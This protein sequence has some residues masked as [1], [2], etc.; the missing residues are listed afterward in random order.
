MTLIANQTAFALRDANQAIVIDV[1]EPAEYVEAHLDGAINLP[2]T[3]FNVNDYQ[4]FGDRAICLICQTGNRAAHIAADLKQHGIKNVYLLEQQMAFLQEKELGV[5][6]GG[7]TID[8][9]FR[10][11]L[12]LLLAIFLVGYFWGVTWFIIIPIILCAGLITT[13]IIDRCYLRTGI[14]M[15]PWN[16]QRSQVG[17]TSVRS[18]PMPTTGLQDTPTTNNRWPDSLRLMH[19][20]SGG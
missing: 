6:I 10:M 5:Q 9:Q 4:T 16:R 13:S 8:R 11:T 2:S 12:G 17:V 7:W 20:E 14:A 1:R 18:K 3:K 15:L 19:T